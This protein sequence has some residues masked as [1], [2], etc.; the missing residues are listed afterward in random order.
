[1]YKFICWVINMVIN[2]LV[3]INVDF[4]ITAS[5]CCLFSKVPLSQ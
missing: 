2:Q 1:M 3:P 5:Q 4:E